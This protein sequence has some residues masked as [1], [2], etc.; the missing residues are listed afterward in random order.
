M[1]VPEAVVVGLVLHDGVSW[2]VQDSSQ[3]V[4]DSGRRRLVVGRPVPDRQDVL[5]TDGL[6]TGQRSDAII[7]VPQAFKLV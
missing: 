3:S 6:Q 7:N 2:K 5:L 4:S 1:V